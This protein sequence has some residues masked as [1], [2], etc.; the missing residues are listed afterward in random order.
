MGAI[1]R[2][3][4]LVVFAAAC[5]VLALGACGGPSAEDLQKQWNKNQEELWKA[6]SK[7][8]NFKAAIDDVLASA[9]KD[10]EAA[11]SA[12]EKTRQ[13]RMKAAN[14]RVGALLRSFTEYDAEIGKLEKYMGD[15]ALTSLPAS[16][17]NPVNDAAK[18]ALEKAAS[19]MKAATPLTGDEARQTIVEATTLLRNSVSQ[20]EALKRSTL[21]TARPTG[22]AAGTGAPTGTAGSTGTAASGTGSPKMS[23]Y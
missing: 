7:F 9:G 22:T 21:G 23:D 6:G 14:E 4:V 8:P 13:D 16:T 20:F 19:A 17:F 15:K 12:E 1:G 2:R 11:K 5:A 3:F 18:Q 10:F